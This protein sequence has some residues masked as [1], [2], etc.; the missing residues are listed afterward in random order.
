MAG[1]HRVANDLLECDHQSGGIFQDSTC[2]TVVYRRDAKPEGYRSKAASSFFH[3]RCAP[4]NRTICIGGLR[5][6]RWAL[7]TLNEQLRY[8]LLIPR[9]PV[10]IMPSTDAIPFFTRSGSSSTGFTSLHTRGNE[11]LVSHTSVER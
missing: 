2:R 5:G 10:P 6:S 4:E 3:E 9:N 7:S 11:P 1:I 8:C